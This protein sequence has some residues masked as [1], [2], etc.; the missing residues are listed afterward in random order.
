MKFVTHTLLVIITAACGIHV[1]NMYTGKNAVFDIMVAGS[2]AVW[3]SLVCWH[4]FRGKY[5]SKEELGELRAER[6]SAVA[7]ALQLQKRVVELRLASDRRLTGKEK[8]T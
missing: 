1:Y 7:Q 3:C 8:L 5:T 4:V 2:Q 6:D